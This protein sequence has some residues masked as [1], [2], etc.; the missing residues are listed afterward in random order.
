VT[1]S[2]FLCAD[3]ATS[4]YKK[5]LATLQ[6][7]HPTTKQIFL[8]PTE[9]I[10][11]GNLLVRLQD[12]FNTTVFQTLWDEV[13][14]NY[15]ARDFMRSISIS[16]LNIFGEKDIRIPARRVRAYADSRIK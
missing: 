16:V 11:A 9:V 5:E 7:E 3:D 1:F 14:T 6:I 4:E 15:D 13:V 8:A 10:P 2:S 12:S